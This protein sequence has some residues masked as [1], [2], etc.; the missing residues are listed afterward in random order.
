MP[1]S[2]SL[3]EQTSLP[4]IT[5]RG[6]NNEPQIEVYANAYVVGSQPELMNNRWAYP[7]YY[8][9]CVA[10]RGQGTTLQGLFARLVSPHSRGATLH[11]VGEVMLAH[12]QSRISDCGY[13]I[14]WNFE[15]A[16]VAPNR[17]LHA[18]IESN[19]LTVCNPVRG[20]AVKQRQSQ[21]NKS[22]GVQKKRG[23]ERASLSTAKS[24]IHASLDEVRHRD[25]HPMFVLLVPSW[26]QDHLLPQ[27][28]FAFLDPRLP[29]PLDPSWATFFWERGQSAQEIERLKVWCFTPSKREDLLEEV[30]A[31]QNTITL[32][33]FSDAYFCRPDPTKIA[34]DIKQ[35]ILSGRISSPLASHLAALPADSPR[36]LPLA[37]SKALAA[38]SM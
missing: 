29:W 7:L 6:K 32:P 27:L 35:A 31:D 3:I 18:V 28:H 10:Q 37:E 24:A 20:M 26:Y 19:M 36:H 21:K 33:F 25:Q 5:V 13:P 23:K 2:H 22:A 34:L 38:S 1:S 16:E 4:K 8:L 15:Q 9:S 12:R 14:H 30:E 11:G 17:D